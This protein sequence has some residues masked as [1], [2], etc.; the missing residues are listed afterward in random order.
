[1][2]INRND[3][4]RAYSNPEWAGHGYLNARKHL[5]VAERAEADRFAINEANRRGWTKAQFFEWLNSA[6][7]RHFADV[8]TASARAHFY[9]WAGSEQ[10]RAYRDAAAAHGAPTL[11]V[12]GYFDGE[13]DP[14]PSP[15]PRLSKSSWGLS[16]RR[17]T[18]PKWT[19]RPR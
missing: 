13:W 16:R 5:S 7:G 2:S 18:R 15:S 4:T 10:G 1:M 19:G 11:D 9:D 8:G 14:S 6:R 12:R 17:A 3:I